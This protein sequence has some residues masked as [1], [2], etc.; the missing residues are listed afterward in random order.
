MLRA[1]PLEAVASGRR[2]LSEINDLARLAVQ[3]EAVDQ[4][5]LR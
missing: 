5:A 1:R 3:G 2:D 4:E